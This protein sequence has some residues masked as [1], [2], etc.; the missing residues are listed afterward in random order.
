MTGVTFARVAL[1]DKK[2][3]ALGVRRGV[4]S[5]IRRP[6]RSDFERFSDAGAASRHEV[7]DEEHERDDQQQMNEPAADVQRETDQ[8]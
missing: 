7:E 1:S 5:T 4:F 6:H 8:P 3:P 2:S